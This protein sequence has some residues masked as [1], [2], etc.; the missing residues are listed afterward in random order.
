[1]TLNTP[2]EL[3]QQITLRPPGPLNPPYERPENSRE[4]RT[5]TNPWEMPIS[6]T[7]SGLLSIAVSDQHSLH[8]PRP[9][10][11]KNQQNWEHRDES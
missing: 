2:P 6:T 8:L 4:E 5:K 3:T 1:M 11:L 9:P 10:S 7:Q